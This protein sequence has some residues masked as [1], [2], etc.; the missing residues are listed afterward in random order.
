MG[1][2]KGAKLMAH[3]DWALV[4]LDAGDHS[5]YKN[6]KRDHSNYKVGDV[7]PA[8]ANTFIRKII[9]TDEGHLKFVCK[10]KKDALEAAAS[11]Q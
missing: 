1:G 8:N 10:A 5:N 2:K 6:K 7:C 9:H 3:G 11:A 4:K